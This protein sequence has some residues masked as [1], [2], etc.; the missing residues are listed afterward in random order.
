[1]HWT[2]VWQ[3]CAQTVSAGY[4]NISW[5]DAHNKLPEGLEYEGYVKPMRQNEVFV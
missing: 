3:L 2:T 1:M 4:H 5:L